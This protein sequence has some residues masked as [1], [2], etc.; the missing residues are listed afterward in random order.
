MDDEMKL[1]SVSEKGSVTKASNHHAAIETTPDETRQR[2]AADGDSDQA[3]PQKVHKSQRRRNPV[4]E[5]EPTH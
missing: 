5:L 1:L 2:L 4:G 3:V